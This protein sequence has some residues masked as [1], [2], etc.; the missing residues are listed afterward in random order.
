MYV[1]MYVGLGRGVF[2]PTKI[3]APDLHT[4]TGP[5]SSLCHDMPFEIWSC[6][7]C[8]EVFDRLWFA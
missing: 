2:A 6:A 3:I 4:H 8:L 5:Y 7:V 1:L